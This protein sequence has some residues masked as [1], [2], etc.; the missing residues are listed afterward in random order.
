M[1]KQ[2]GFNGFFK[3]IGMAINIFVNKYPWEC[4]DCKKKDIARISVL[5]MDY[6]V[7][8]LIQRDHLRKSPKCLR[9]AS[10]VR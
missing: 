9:K 5:R 1:E 7:D 4:K 2:E 8:C 3:K 6:D 10:L